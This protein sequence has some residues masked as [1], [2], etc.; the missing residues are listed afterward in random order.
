VRSAARQ[1]GGD[2]T[3]RQRET[4]NRKGQRTCVPG[5]AKPLTGRPLLD[6][7]RMPRLVPLLLMGRANDVPGPGR[8]GRTG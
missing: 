5:R 1:R 7:G 3:V 4:S 2:N 6:I 8:D